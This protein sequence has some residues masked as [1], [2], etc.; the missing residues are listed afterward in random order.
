MAAKKKTISKSDFIRSLPSNLSGSQVVA[1][2]KAA[3][4]KLSSTLVYAVRGRAK[5]K[6][7]AS[8]NG[9]SSRKGTS[10]AAFVRGLPSSTPAKEVVSKA[11]AAGMKLTESY[12]YNVRGA[13]KKKGGAGPKAAPTSQS[14]S[15][16]VESL[17]RAVG[18]ELGLARA[19]AVLQEE[20]AK[21]RS[22]LGA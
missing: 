3:G 2:A 11:K 10:K 17:L 21:V 13:A 22:V 1:K 15:S 9:A 16:S 8:G 5:G 4:M 20:R 18:S 12:V 6:G 19:I 14:S 7:A